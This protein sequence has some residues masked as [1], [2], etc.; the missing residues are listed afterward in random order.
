MSSFPKIASPSEIFT[1]VGLVANYELN[2]ARPIVEFG[3]PTEIPRLIEKSYELPDGQI[4]TIGNERFRA[5]EPLFQASV[6]GLDIGGLHV[7]AFNSIMKCDVDIRKDLWENIVL[8]SLSFYCY[9]EIL[10]IPY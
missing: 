5:V 4:I 3:A 8:V 7:H 10:T 1:G 9:K 6:M 2:T